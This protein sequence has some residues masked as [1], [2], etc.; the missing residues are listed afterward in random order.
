MSEAI[1][2]PTAQEVEQSEY[3]DLPSVVPVKVETPVRVQDLPAPNVAFNQITIPNGTSAKVLLR[4]LKRRRAFMRGLGNQLWL[5]AT[6][7]QAQ[8]KTGFQLSAQV[9]IEMFH[10]NEV[11]AFADTA[12]VTLSV[13]EEFWA[14]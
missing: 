14:N 2:E 10:G 7:Q 4:N 3:A 8:S 6:Q 1:G 9:Q 13:M 5:G 11:W 12:D